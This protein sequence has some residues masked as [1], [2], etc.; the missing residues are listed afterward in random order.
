MIT[1]SYTP[2]WVRV[3]DASGEP[4]GHAIAFTINRSAEQYAGTLTQ[5]ELVHRLAN[6]RGSLGSSADY[7]FQT[8]EGLRRLGIIDRR[9]EHLAARV[10][11]ATQLVK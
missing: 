11:A 3:R 10:E 6:A 2:R 7:L 5:E 9:I 4:F 8:R 1:G